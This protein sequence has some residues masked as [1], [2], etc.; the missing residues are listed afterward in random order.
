MSLIIDARGLSCPQP[1]VLA[2]KGLEKASDL[3]VIVD[4]ATAEENVARLA[5]GHGMEVK[6]DRKGDGVYLR[7]TRPADQ[8]V[9]GKAPLLYE[10]TVLLVTG[11]TLGRGDN[12]LG[13]VLMRSFMHTLV[14][15]D[16]KPHHIIFMNSGVSLAAEGS[17]VV[18]DLRALED[19]GVEVL[20]CGTC[21]AQFGLK[22]AVR[23]GRVSNMYEITQALMK[24][25][26]VVSI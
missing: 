14:E 7:L 20:S 6:V 9:G 26:R 8:A 19:E 4:N 16:I 21:L 17:D 10:P 22:D 3:T 13:A 5:E 23:A 25:T 1:A 2:R 11:S 18:D 15:S 24:A 12:D